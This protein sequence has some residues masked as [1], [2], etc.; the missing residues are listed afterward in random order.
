MPDRHIRAG[1][2]LGVRFISAQ[3]WIDT[4]SVMGRLE[5]LEISER[6]TAGISAI[7]EAGRR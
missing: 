7:R 1:G 3:N 6:V 4:D 2:H 5:S